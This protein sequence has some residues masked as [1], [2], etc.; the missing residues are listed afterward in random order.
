MKAL[1][2]EDR[3]AAF[4]ARF[5]RFPGAVPSIGQE[6]GRSVLYAIWILGNRYGN[7]SDYYGSYPHGFLPRTMALFPERRRREEILHAFS[8][9]LRRGPYLRLD[10]NRRLEP[11]LVGEVT[12]VARLVRGRP[13]S[14]VV[15]DPPY[16]PADA[17]RYGMPMVNRNRAIAALGRVV[18]RGGFL[19]WLDTVWPMHRVDEWVT[20]G[21]I[22][23]V[24]S[25]N[26]R[27]R[28]CSIFQRVA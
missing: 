4:R 20:V 28:L 26:H 14:L 7:H 13:F 6:A 11:E 8:G 10:A 16:S 27:V 3:V 22:F 18:R 21:R 5:P 15:A 19:V 2:L 9:S 12:N 24:I 17:K 25:T 23:L 1:A